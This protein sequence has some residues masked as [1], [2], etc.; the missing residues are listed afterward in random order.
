MTKEDLKRLRELA[1]AAEGSGQCVCV[2]PRD[3]LGLLDSMTT[4]A[5]A[6]HALQVINN[7]QRKLLDSTICGRGPITEAEWLRVS[8]VLEGAQAVV[9]GSP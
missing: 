7:E 1:E 6:V 9:G 3:M 5:R 4:M 8:R 2:N